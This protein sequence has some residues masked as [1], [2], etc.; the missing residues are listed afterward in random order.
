MACRFHILRFHRLHRSCSRINKHQWHSNNAAH[1]TTQIS[2]Q[3]IIATMAAAL[4]TSNFLPAEHSPKHSLL[5]NAHPLLSVPHEHNSA[6]AMDFAVARLRAAV[7]PCPGR[8]QRR[9]GPHHE[10]RPHG[11]RTG[12]PSSRLSL[13]RC[14][15]E[16][17]S[18]ACSGLGDK[19]ENKMVGIAC[20]SHL[21]TLP[22][23]PG[24]SPLPSPPDASPPAQAR[25]AEILAF[26]AALPPCPPGAQ[27]PPTSPARLISSSPVM[28]K[29]M[30]AGCQRLQCSLQA[31]GVQQAQAAGATTMASPALH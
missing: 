4:L 27:R 15:R 19:T 17:A 13:P 9:P 22:P 3:T 5:C 12:K 25:P 29:M 28:T 14:A 18:S 1:E 6:R 26:L 21:R 31:A 2:S 11:Q 30:V 7:P 23:S 24:R 10:P 20:L 8:G 16:Q